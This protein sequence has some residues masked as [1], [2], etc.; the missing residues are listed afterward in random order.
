MPLFFCS[1]E[2]L[3][4][5]LIFTPLCIREYWFTEEMKFC[6][7]PTRSVELEKHVDSNWH[8]DF[9][10][11][12]HLVFLYNFYFAERNFELHNFYFS[13]ATFNLSFRLV[14]TI[15]PNFSLFFTTSLCSGSKLIITHLFF[16][17]SIYCRQNALFYEHC[18]N[19]MY[20]YYMAFMRL[21]FNIGNFI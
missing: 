21:P 19:R 14:S 17:S 4:F 16:P 6:S 7:T 9:I 13:L 8:T 11:Q 20:V 3:Q 18:A 10:V 12:M 15:I 5:S 2:V 1:L